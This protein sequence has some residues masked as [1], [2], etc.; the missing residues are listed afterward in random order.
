[1]QNKM[2]NT[3]NRKK[4]QPRLRKQPGPADRL[5]FLFFNVSFLIDL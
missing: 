5:S 2:Q 1:M 4:P 3:E